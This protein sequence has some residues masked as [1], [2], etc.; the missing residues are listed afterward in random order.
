LDFGSISEFP[1]SKRARKEYIILG[2]IS[3]IS[4]LDGRV[5]GEQIDDMLTR[6]LKRNRRWQTIF[7][8]FRFSTTLLLIL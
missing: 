1:S 5:P 3:R 8:S 7:V 4:R 6:L 2:R